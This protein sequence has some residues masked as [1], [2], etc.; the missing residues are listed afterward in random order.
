MEAMKGTG[1]ERCSRQRRDVR[2]G[3][4]LEDCREWRIWIGINFLLGH[5]FMLSRNLSSYL[6]CERHHVRVWFRN[7]TDRAAE[8]RQEEEWSCVF[9]ENPHF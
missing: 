7:K 9:L 3:E 4:E 5:I 2:R 1:E 6:Q 8:R